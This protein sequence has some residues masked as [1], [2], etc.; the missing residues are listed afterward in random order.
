MNDVNRSN[1]SNSV[2]NEILKF[3]KENL[4]EA[5]KKYRMLKH[6]RGGD[7]EQNKNLKFEHNTFSDY[8]KMKA[9]KLNINRL[10]EIE[11][12][13]HI[14]KSVIKEGQVHLPKTYKIER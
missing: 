14:H 2:K 7:S 1:L 12:D 13:I 11:E 9:K 6:K 3:Y 8:S 4:K 10:N 5:L